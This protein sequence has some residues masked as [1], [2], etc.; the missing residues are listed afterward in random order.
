MSRINR[1]KIKKASINYEILENGNNSGTS[2]PGVR[3]C[4][5]FEGEYVSYSH[6]KNNIVFNLTFT[7]VKDSPI[8]FNVSSG[9]LGRLYQNSVSSIED[10]FFKILKLKTLSSP[11]IA[12]ISIDSGDITKSI[13]G[14]NLIFDLELKHGIV[15]EYETVTKVSA[16]NVKSLEATILW[17]EPNSK[18]IIGF[19]TQHRKLNDVSNVNWVR[20]EF[21]KD[22]KAILTLL[23]P[24]T[25]YEVQVMVKYKK[26]VS[27]FSESYFFKTI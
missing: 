15:D 16:T 14:D 23:E 8:E 6:I 18:F 11:W 21:D 24:K 17:S 3:N 19:I 20:T 1:S 25:R 4:N 13:I 10:V 5:S 22:V 9:V 12:E 26:G 27:K 2:I 7:T